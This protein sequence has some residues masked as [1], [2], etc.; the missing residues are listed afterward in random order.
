MIA[1]LKPFRPAIPVGAV[2][3]LVEARLRKPTYADFI[4]LR[5]D[6]RTLGGWYRNRVARTLLVFML[7]N[8]GMIA[9]E[10]TAIAR[11]VGKFTG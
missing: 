2:S 5:D 8:F 9:G 3:A 4:S 11:I 7:T 6:V 10:L 1:P